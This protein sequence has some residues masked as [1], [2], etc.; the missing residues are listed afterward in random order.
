MSQNPYALLLSLDSESAPE[1]DKSGAAPAAA[2]P[3]KALS[4]ASDKQMNA[5]KVGTLYNWAAGYTTKDS[6]DSFVLF[7]D[8][9]RGFAL[10]TTWLFKVIPKYLAKQIMSDWGGDENIALSPTA[11]SY[12][13][14]TLPTSR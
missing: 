11:V 9:A 10:L 2:A 13:H 8:K 14:L 5:E 1:S 6:S 12:T 3:A 7:S 4:L